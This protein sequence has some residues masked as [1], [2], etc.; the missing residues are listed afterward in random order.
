MKAN[1]VI[2]FGMFAAMTLAVAGPVCAGSGKAAVHASSASSVRSAGNV[3]TPAGVQQ[4]APLRANNRRFFRPYYPYYGYGYGNQ[5]YLNPDEADW[6]E[7]WRSLRAENNGPYARSTWGNPQGEARI[8]EFPDDA[9]A[10]K[11]SK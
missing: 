10:P 5:A 7:Q 3:A 6:A 4:L 2:A 1:K 9:T 8:W 11:P